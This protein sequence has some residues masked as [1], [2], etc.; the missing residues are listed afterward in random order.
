MRDKFATDPF[1]KGLHTTEIFGSSGNSPHIEP[2]R[3]SRSLP[4]HG[5]GF[6]TQVVIGLHRPLAAVFLS[7][8][9][10][11]CDHLSPAHHVIRLG[12]YLRRTRRDFSL[13][14]PANFDF[15]KMPRPPGC[16]KTSWVLQSRGQ[17]CFHTCMRRAYRKISL[18][19]CARGGGGAA[20]DQI[21]LFPRKKRSCAGFFSRV[22]L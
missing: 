5:N 4:G 19:Y 7:F 16:I 20:T 10:R 22:K 1:Y 14:R 8:S 13:F 21:F 17:R 2:V 6:A 3:F 18:G 12:P 15:A 11:D 9:S